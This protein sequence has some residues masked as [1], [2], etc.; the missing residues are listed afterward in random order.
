MGGEREVGYAYC[1]F[2]MRMKESTIAA[3]SDVKALGAFA[4]ETIDS[5]PGRLWRTVAARWREGG[6]RVRGGVR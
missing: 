3:F 2:W 6:V 5:T 4:H 1:R